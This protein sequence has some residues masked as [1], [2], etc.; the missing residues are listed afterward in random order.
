[1]TQS[2]TP[3]QNMPVDVLGEPANAARSID[4]QVVTL[5]GVDVLDQRQISRDPPADAT[6]LYLAIARPCVPAPI[7]GTKCDKVG[8]AVTV[9]V[10]D[11][12]NIR[13]QS[14]AKTVDEVFAISIDRIPF[15]IFRAPND[16]VVASIIVEALCQM[17]S[18]FGASP[19]T[20]PSS[21]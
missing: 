11:Q 9:D 13:A 14:P 15:A 4:D 21:G 17:A 16:E 10:A 8:F 20:S 3:Q 18:S 1:M 2:K 19:L 12:G 6:H 5:I 7:R